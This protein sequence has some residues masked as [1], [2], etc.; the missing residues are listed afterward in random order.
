MSRNLT[1]ASA[2][3]LTLVV[4]DA[5]AL[6]LGGLQTYS[7]L[8]QP[9]RGDIVLIDVDPDTLDTVRIEL[10]PAEAFNRAG[11]ERY[12]YL[13]QLEFEPA[14]TEGGLPVV[15]VTSRE[16]VREPYLD[17]LV[18]ATWPE[19]Q[20]VRGYTVL[21][22]P[23]VSTPARAPAVTAPRVSERPVRAPA[24]SST[25]VEQAAPRSRSAPAAIELPEGVDSSVFP[26]QVG[27]VPE[28][29]G[30]WQFALE[31]RSQGA[32]LA[33]TAMALYRA[34]QDAFI[35]GDI[36]R[37][38][39]GE[40]LT[41]PSAEELFA[42][43]PAT[44]QTEFQAAMRGESVNRAPLAPSPPEPAR[45][46]I[47]GE[48]GEMPGRDDETQPGTSS[49]AR[50]AE[51]VALEQELMTVMQAHE[52][53][54][55]ET[56]ELRAHIR[57]LESQL[58]EIKELLRV[59]NAEVARLQAATTVVDDVESTAAVEPV[60][61]S[62]AAASEPV[63][64]P[65]A[66]EAP[67]PVVSER[68]AS[69]VDEP[70][71]SEPP[72]PQSPPS[73]PEPV[74]E[75]SDSLWHALLLPLAGFAALAA[76]GLIGFS[77]W[78]SRRRQRED[79]E[80]VSTLDIESEFEPLDVPARRTTEHDTQIN[81]AAE[82]SAL[83]DED[84]SGSP[85]SSLTQFDSTLDEA[86]PLSEADIFIAYG[87]YDEAVR[88]L[89]GALD[90]APG[91]MD[92]RLKLAEAYF[93]TRDVA[94]LEALVE[95]GRAADGE[96]VDPAGWQRLLEMH[97]A[98]VA[99]GEDA[100]PSPAGDAGA[101]GLDL[102]SESQESISLH[103][104]DVADPAPASSGE[105]P[106]PK[107]ETEVDADDFDLPLLFDDTDLEESAPVEAARAT[108]DGGL[109][110]E[111]AAVPRPSAPEAPS[112][113]DGA[114]KPAVDDDSELM[115]TLEDLDGF[116][117]T[118]LAPQSTP[119]PLAPEPSARPA[120]G[121]EVK[122]VADTD[123]S[124]FLLSQWEMDSGLWDENATKLD[125]ARAYLDMDDKEAARGILEEVLADGRE[126]QRQEARQ[127]LD[128]LG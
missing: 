112:D 3:A 62:V 16:P 91:R 1:L 8:N 58:V 70:A 12:H 83:V 34:N 39:A 96:R 19:G 45:L 107:P 57:E 28:G 36:N 89:H 85:F 64:E 122:P 88:L 81:E 46:R 69:A 120:G 31:S 97:S 49:P 48:V 98:L 102:P 116:S 80:L 87:R 33:Q 60:V 24:P 40:T 2:L 118:D 127:L 35:R 76:L 126:D 13:T 41:I 119:Q 113:S 52:S 37:L 123:P 121:G 54:R 32:S 124:E 106:K 67:A 110:D 105:A 43:D 95:D 86:D 78:S 7:A 65:D 25:T 103:L 66:S 61:P 22:D 92:L 99:G 20:L 109:G 9:F 56:L 93:A 90:A 30:L 55:Q 115:L 14:V 53:T 114:S 111:R 29:V 59:R 44:A 75:A 84:A 18:A 104:E 73:V 42:L 117:D 4:A 108:G 21:L 27:P 47:A 128:K 94:A 101:V 71:P 26:V 79:T 50:S 125:L 5:S 68:E 63:V 82:P 100:S 17:F 74:P 11:L 6:G 10:A 38:V 72:A 51:V 23:P 77:W 15:R